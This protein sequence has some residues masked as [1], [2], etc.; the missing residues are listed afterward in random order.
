MK[1]KTKLPKKFRK[2]SDWDFS[3]TVALTLFTIA[4]LWSIY[5]TI[6]LSPYWVIAVIFASA[7]TLVGW[8]VFLERETHWEE[9]D[10]N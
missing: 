9:I 2:V 8:I 4:F 10:E 5:N 7:F 6:Y 3:Q 1:Q